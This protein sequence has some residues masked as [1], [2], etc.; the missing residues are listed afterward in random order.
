[1]GEAVKTFERAS[2]SLDVSAGAILLLGLLVLFA[3]TGRF[4]LGALVLDFSQ[5]A[6]R[7]VPASAVVIACLI[8]FLG[9][10]L[11]VNRHIKS[12]KARTGYYATGLVVMLVV[13]VWT[14]FATFFQSPPRYTISRWGCD[15]ARGVFYLTV[16]G[17]DLRMHDNRALMAVVVPDMPLS[18]DDV[19]LDFVVKASWSTDATENSIVVRIDNLANHV[20]IG[21]KLWV[22]LYSIP[23]NTTVD[24]LMGLDELNGIG[25]EPL[26]KRWTTYDITK[27]T[28]EG[29]LAGYR[30]MSPS[31]RAVFMEEARRIEQ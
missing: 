23:K 13:L 2:N 22:H 28:P 6:P 19:P 26:A 10:A 20:L 7:Y 16:N 25:A 27:A 8:I 29:L 15:P 9:S 14:A 17:Q 11:L 3:G 12:T 4:Q 31:Q 5:H 30:Q 1:M 21:D 18:G 24:Q